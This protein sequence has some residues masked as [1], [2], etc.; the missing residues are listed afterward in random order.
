LPCLLR[1]LQDITWACR[2]EMAACPPYVRR[3]L[4]Q[5]AAAVAGGCAVGTC[6]AGLASG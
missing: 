4:Q 6:G 2:E 1:R 3:R 5:A